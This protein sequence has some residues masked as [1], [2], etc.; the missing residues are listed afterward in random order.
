MLSYE[1]FKNSF[2][3]N[4][5]ARLLLDF[6][7]SLS[8]FYATRLTNGN[9]FFCIFEHVLSRLSNGMI[10]WPQRATVL[11]HGF[12]WSVLRIWDSS[13]K[14]QTVLGRLKQFSE[15]LNSSQKCQTVFGSVKQF[16]E[17]SNSSRK[18]QTV[19]RSLK[20]FSEVS[21]SSQRRIK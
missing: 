20:Q 8:C 4:T 13:W 14:C 11:F 2:L 12:F 1:I 17:I 18:F 15:L 6:F 16:S 7:H 10:R 3:Q 9:Q 21:N 5:S 19:L